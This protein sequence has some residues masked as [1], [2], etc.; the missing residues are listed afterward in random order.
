MSNGILR[1][2]RTRTRPG[3]RT[4]TQRRLAAELLACLVL[5]ATPALA[6]AQ[7]SGASVR[8]QVMAGSAPVADA[9]IVVFNPATGLR[10]SVQAG[11]DGRYAVAGLPPGSYR[12]EVQSGDRTAV[13]ELTVQVG[14]TV[15][16]DLALDAGGTT[17]LDTVQVLGVAVE[18]RTSEIATYVTPRQIEALPQGTR[19]FLAFADLVPG[20][21][22]QHDAGG[23]TRLRSG[24]QNASAINVY[25]DGVG[26]KGYTLPGGIGGQDSTRGNPFPQSA[27][28]EYKVITS[29]YKAE[30]DQIGSAAVVAATR[31]GGNEFGGG[32][33]WD[34]THA[35]WRAPTPAE[36]R[37]RLKVPSREEQYGVSFAGPIVRDRLN[38]FIAYEAKDYSTPR[39]VELGA[40]GR[41]DPAVLPPG[42]LAQLGPTASPFGQDLYFG[43]LTWTADDR[44]LVELSA[45]VRDEDERV[46]VG[47]NNTA[48]HA[49]VNRNRVSRYDLRW[50]YN[51]AD[52]LNDAHLTFE[53][54]SWSPRATFAGN[55]YI[56]QVSEPAA[57][58]RLN[59][60]TIL[61][62]G[63]SPNH[64]DKGQ[65]G[66]SLQD[67]FT[68]LGWER[69]TLK[70][71]VKVKQVEVRAVE[72]H[73]ANAQFHYDLATGLGQP[74]RVEF[75]TGDAGTSGGFTR[76]A[77]RQFGIYLQDDWEV[78][79]RLTVN[80]GLRWDYETTPAYEDF[81][82]PAALAADIRAFPNFRNADWDPEDYLSNG[83]N[84]TAFSGA[85]Q[86]RLGFSYDLGA[87]QR[88]VLYGGAGRAYDR[89][90]FDY[91]QLEINRTSFGRYNFF[92]TDADGVC[93]RP[94]GDCVAWN[95]AYLQP[96]VLD[97]LAAGVDL[98]REWY[99]NNNALK[100]PYS[101]QFSLGI[102]NAFDLGTQT[103]YSDVSVAHVRSHDGI[104][105][106]L[107]NRRPDGSFLPPGGS[108][109][110]PWGFDPPFGR[111][112]LVDSQFRTRATS[113]LLKLDKPYTTSSR[114]GATFAYTWTHGRQNTNA[115][116]GIDMFEYP[117]AGYYGWLPSRGVPGHRL[118]S[119]GIWGIGTGF[120]FSGKL[121]LESSRYRNAT[122]C[123]GGWNDCIIDPYR[124]RGTIG[125]KRL[126]LAASRE[127]DTGSAVRFRIRADLLNV[128]D[129]HNRD[130]WDD[131]YG[132][133]GDPNPN[134]GA[135]SDS[136]IGGTRTFKLSLA[137]DW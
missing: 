8:G 61:N 6:L 20:M 39:T 76:S 11:A 51:A 106:R 121:V 57:N 126:D 75:G 88:H 15:T 72:R 58:D 28:G 71:G 123:L 131:W 68:W 117:E 3:R 74:Y 108:W 40:P 104:T 32:F 24:A 21:Q 44:N 49:T 89:N 103:W 86:P 90:L 47:G 135:P 84:R 53:D 63:A 46:G 78:S 69:H 41:Y 94:G 85:W 34:R 45:Q 101:D 80:L 112:V 130:G 4:A 17:T 10:R 116:G 100:V 109:G 129:W 118:V 25:I 67:D 102:R 95:P 14:Q 16:L 73:F 79:E 30:Y 87:D 115:D 82:T 9:G 62:T 98:P 54:L 137:I 52:W 122:N 132:G 96:G 37:S 55:G 83:R 111:I 60:G 48:E 66:G 26:Q 1:S 27:I 18:T 99:L 35:D 70:M 119:S 59:V 29:N 42:I 113:L 19:N 114:W 93:R 136:I 5:A 12:I 36:Q 91:L 120:T 110:T 125:Y 56:L 81:V 33:F 7:G 43:K 38:F 127:F 13:R 92:F 23:N 97:Q 65:R 22:F 31:S 2:S 107:G 128:F 124:P 50:Q 133:P 134:F 105:A 77:N 64:Q